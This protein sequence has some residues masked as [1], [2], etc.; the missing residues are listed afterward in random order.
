MFST[1]PKTPNLV[2][3][4]TAVNRETKEGPA[5]VKEAIAFLKAIKA[6]IKEAMKWDQ[7]CEFEAK[8]LVTEQ[9]LTKEEGHD[10][11]SGVTVA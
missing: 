6:P 9:S 2:I 5:A 11:P 10:T 3:T 1:N 4:G 8:D 7:Y